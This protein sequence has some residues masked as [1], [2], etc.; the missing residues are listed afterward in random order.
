MKYNNPAYSGPKSTYLRTYI[1]ISSGLISIQR[2][3]QIQI[4]WTKPDLTKL[5]EECIKFDSVV[6]ILN[7]LSK[8]DA[9]TRKLN[10]QHVIQ[11]AVT[12]TRFF[13]DTLPRNVIQHDENSIFGVDFA[14]FPIAFMLHDCITYDINM[15]LLWWMGVS[16]SRYQIISS[17]WDIL[18]M[19]TS[20][21][22]S[23]IEY[24]RH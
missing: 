4:H 20:W 13:H 2:Q 12:K 7:P 11:L 23:N 3:I 19:V 16:K 8:F 6:G 14:S 5:K 15:T 17:S 10:R 1:L 21:F 9:T 18:S 24:R 22:V